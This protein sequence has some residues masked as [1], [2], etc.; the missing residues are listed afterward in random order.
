MTKPKNTLTIDEYFQSKYSP[1]E[2]KQ[3]DSEAEYLI[4]IMK[5]KEKRKAMKL[6]QNELSKLS[7]IPRETISHIESGTRN[8]TLKTLINIAHGM[9]KKLEVQLV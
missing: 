1:E 2:I 9:G 7:G 5:L 8:A 3:L 6:T 4:A